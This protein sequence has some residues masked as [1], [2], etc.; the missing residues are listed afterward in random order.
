MKLLRV[1]FAVMLA[2]G[3]SAC[4]AN[5]EDD[6]HIDT[7]ETNPESSSENKPPENESKKLPA[8]QLLTKDRAPISS[9]DA[10]EGMTIDVLEVGLKNVVVQLKETGHT[11]AFDKYLSA[12]ILG[13]YSFENKKTHKNIR[14]D[15]FL[16]V[17]LGDEILFYDF[18]YYMFLDES[19]YLRDIDGDGLDEIIVWQQ[20]GASGGEGQHCSFVFKIINDELKMIFESGPSRSKFDTGFSGTLQDGFELKIENKF[21]SYSITL[22]LKTNRHFDKN[23]KVTIREDMAVYCFTK[24]IPEDIDGDGIFEIVCSQYA[25][26]GYHNEGI[27]KAKSILKFNSTLQTFEVIQAEFIPQKGVSAVA[28]TL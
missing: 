19:L 18:D 1:C 16:A 15:A 26:L 17:E 7:T 12:Y 4:T 20:V 14:C 11:V 28:E 22:D 3:L 9:L 27:G 6:A 5:T 21:T 8:H 24:F 25:S 13:D 23:G 2:F 10:E